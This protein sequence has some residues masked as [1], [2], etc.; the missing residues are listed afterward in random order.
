MGYNSIYKNTQGSAVVKVFDLTVASVG[1]S[2][3]Q[4]KKLN[5]PYLKTFIFSNSHAGYYPNATKT[6][7]KFMFSREGEILGVQA[8]GFEGVEKRVDVISAIMRNHGK[9]QDMLDSELCYA[10]PYSSAKDPVNILGMHSD[11][12]LK[13]FMKP[14]FYEDL[15]DSLLVDVR[16]PEFFIKETIEGAIN[17]PTSQMR[18]RLNEIPESKKVIL[19][20]NTGFQSYVASRILIQ[21]GFTNIYSLCGG[22]E[23]YKILIRDKKYAETQMPLIAK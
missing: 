9:I 11:N 7:Y 2:E 19:F 1:N 13:G 12:I 23:L 3:K 16:E 6:L 17:I 20:C 10:P 14:A 15:A 22:I 8:A 4:L 18:E 21:R 5:I